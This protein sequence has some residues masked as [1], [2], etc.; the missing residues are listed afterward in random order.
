[1]THDV[2]DVEGHEYNAVLVICVVAQDVKES[3][4]LGIA[5]IAAIEARCQLPQAAEMITRQKDTEAW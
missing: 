3:L 2:G 4:K 1:M 5:C